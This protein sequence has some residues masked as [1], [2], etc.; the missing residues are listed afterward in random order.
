MQDDTIKKSPY[1]GIVISCIVLLAV[2]VSLYFLFKC[3]IMNAQ[4]TYGYEMNKYTSMF[5]GFGSGFLFQFSCVI[6]GLFR[7]SLNVVIKRIVHFFE[8]LTISFKFACKMYH[9]EFI[10]DGAVFW[11]LLLVIGSTLFTSIYGLINFI[12]LYF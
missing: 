4:Y 1:K 5:L 10:E 2:P 3:V 9:D 12:I 11:I 7:G 6:G 8:N